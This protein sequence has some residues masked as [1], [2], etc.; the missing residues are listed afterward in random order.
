MATTIKDVARMA[1]V[2]ASSVSRVIN[3]S[4]HTSP[5]MRA[6]VMAAIS[7]SGFS[8]NFH[9]SEL[10]KNIREKR[11]PSHLAPL[12]NKTLLKGSDFHDA[13]RPAAAWGGQLQA[14]ERECWRLRRLATS[15]TKIL[16][17]CKATRG[18]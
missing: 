8:P 1:G 5:A 2:S 15:L 11:T 14:F 7:R 4:T 13:P 17:Q 12:R 9:A 18:S 16:E 10:R 6:K 3:E